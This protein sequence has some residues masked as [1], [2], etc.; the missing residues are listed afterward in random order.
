MSERSECPCESMLGAFEHIWGAPG[1]RPRQRDRGRATA[2]RV[3]RASSPFSAFWQHHGF[4]VRFCNPRS[5]HE[6][7][8]VESTV[9]F[10]GRNLMAP[11]PEA[12]D[13]RT[14]DARMLAGCDAPLDREHCCERVPAR[15]LL[16]GDVA[17]L[18]PLPSALLGCVR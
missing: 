14:L 4:V 17:A 7:G 10:P 15:R 2:G 9:G 16:A 5:G 13:L 11:V 3:V 18:P 12:P 1:A 8:S 6:R